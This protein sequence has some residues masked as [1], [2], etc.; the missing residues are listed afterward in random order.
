MSIRR[1]SRR[2][3]ALAAT[4]VVSLTLCACSS[5]KTGSTTTT[6]SA[7]TS[8]VGASSGASGTQAKE[9]AAAQAV[10]AQYADAPT[11]ISVTEPLPSAPP[12]GKTIVWL[13]C[14][15]ATC[16]SI[17]KGIKDAAAAVGWNY[18][19]INY[20]TANPATLTAAF[21]QALKISPKPVAVAES[22][23]PPESGWSSIE[24]AYKAAGIA[25]IASYIG[26]TALDSPIIANVGGSSSFAL[27]GK[28]VGNWFIADSG[29][30]GKAVVQR[31][32]SYPVLKAYSDSLVATIK[33]G[34]SQCD[35]SD[36]LSNSAADAGANKVVPTIVSALK[37]D[38]SAKYLL[39]VDYE[40]IDGL[41]SAMSAASIHVKIGS[42]DPDLAALGYLKNGT[43][44]MAPSHPL[45]QSGW[46]IADAAF[47]QAE[48]QPVPA[49]DN[50]PLPT[51]ILSQGKDFPTGSLTEWPT[52]YQAQFKALWHV[53]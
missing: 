26:D 22:G 35:I 29:A 50:A 16:T 10:L 42:E 8:G 34:C 12:K 46:M 43:Y 18:K 49:S 15:L 2:W 13:N 20:D 47:R 7:A 53:G 37:R 19:E 32:D 24:P 51:W 9:V 1:R 36:V 3:L 21:Q 45:E 6:S 11:K 44:A 28:I 41:P 40:F 30:Q 4:S 25:I 48:N 27:W 38:S 5:A 52:D 23:N 14:G 31:I 17:G 39:P 33:A